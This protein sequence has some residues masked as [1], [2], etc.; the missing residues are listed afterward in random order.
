M[1]DPLNYMGLK[2]LSCYGFKF[3]IIHASTISNQC[4]HSNSDPSTNLN[5]NTSNYQL[6]HIHVIP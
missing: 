4:T 1:D 3:L 6:L 2:V 5:N